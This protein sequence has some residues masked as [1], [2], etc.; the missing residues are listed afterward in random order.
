[1][2]SSLGEKKKFWWD[3]R[4]KKPRNKLMGT[5]RWSTGHT[6]HW[7]Q[8]PRLGPC[9]SSKTLTS[10]EVTS[11][12]LRVLN[13]T[14]NFIICLKY[15]DSK[16]ILWVVIDGMDCGCQNSPSIQW[17]TWL[18]DIIGIKYCGYWL[19]SFTFKDVAE[20]WCRQVSFSSSN[21]QKWH[22]DLKT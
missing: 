17:K 10:Q 16:S 19:I 21:C 8:L 2:R 14:P 18:F 9:Q 12:H 6:A 7:S 5:E 3:E 22:C 11:W 4:K 13:V 20:T 1:M 15:F